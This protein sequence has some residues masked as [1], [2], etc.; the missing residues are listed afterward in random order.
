MVEDKKEKFGMYVTS[1]EKSDRYTRYA[2]FCLT[3]IPFPGTEF[4]RSWKENRYKGMF[5]LCIVLM[6]LVQYLLWK[7]IDRMKV[8]WD[9]FGTSSTGIVLDP[10][11]PIPFSS[12]DWKTWD[13]GL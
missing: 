13:I 4:F 1:S 7:C 12:Y 8:N 3:A 11:G 5:C 6:K 10:E 9:E 2:E